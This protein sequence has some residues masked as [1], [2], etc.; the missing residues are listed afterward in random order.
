MRK[1][2]NNRAE[3]DGEDYNESY[4]SLV[5]HMT[6][7]LERFSDGESVAVL[8]TKVICKSTE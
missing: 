6:I 5:L 2:R 7:D 1:L 4:M 8:V 3:R